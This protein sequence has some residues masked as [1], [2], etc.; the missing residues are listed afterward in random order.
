MLKGHYVIANF[1]KI[2]GTS[3]YDRSRLGGK[4]LTQRGLCAFNVAR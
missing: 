3:I 1:S 2:F 4:Q